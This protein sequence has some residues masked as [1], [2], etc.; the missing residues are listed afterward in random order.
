MAYGIEQPRFSGHET[1]PLRQLWLKKTYD[2]ISPNSPNSEKSIFSDDD[3]IVRFGVGK[4]MV[5]SLKHWALATDIIEENGNYFKTTLLADL[6]FGKQGLDPFQEKEATSWLIHWKLS[7]EAKKSSTWFWL[8]NLIVEPSFDKDTLIKKH[9]EFASNQNGNYTDNT[10]KRDLDCCLRSYLPKDTKVTP[11]EINDTVLG[12]LNI[13]HRSGSGKYE[14]IRGEKPSMP[15]AIF[16]Y[17]LIKFWNIY[18]PDQQ[19]M[20]FD[21]IMHEN[22]SPG[23]VFKL[24]E[25]SVSERLSEIENITEGKIIW[26]DSQGIRTL[27]RVDDSI[28]PNTIL[29]LAY[30]E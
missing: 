17:A 22:R 6:I 15:N 28:D 20:S 5:N 29:K 16:V 26:T 7:G 3:A 23:R 14:F 21:S 27:S 18:S 13:L 24:D 10:L 30:E 19:S 25:D 2:A 8:F 4:N 11:E 12:D 9:I 1:F